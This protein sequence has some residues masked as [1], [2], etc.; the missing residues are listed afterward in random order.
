MPRPL[1]RDTKPIAVI[2]PDPDPDGRSV[3]ETPHTNPEHGLG[4]ETSAEAQ[5]LEGLTKNILDFRLRHLHIQRP[6]TIT[7]PNIEELCRVVP[8]P[9]EGRH[10][11]YASDGSLL[12][13]ID[14]TVG[15]FLPWPRRARWRV[16]ITRSNESPSLYSAPKGTIR[17]WT[18]FVIFSPLWAALGLLGLLAGL[19]GAAGGGFMWD[20]PARTKWRTGVLKW[21]LD[22]RSPSDTYYV[23]TEIMDFRVAYAQA[24]IHS[25]T[26]H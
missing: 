17:A 14:R 23:N 19:L 2:I 9:D 8:K 15:R 12:A 6:F 18:S 11:V 13:R 1:H 21:G 10:Y 7:S 16:E 22:F 24:V 26:P 20:L 4:T 3:S 5:H 25:W